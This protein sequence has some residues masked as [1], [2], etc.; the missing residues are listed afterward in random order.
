MENDENILYIGDADVLGG[1]AKY[2]NDYENQWGFSSTGDFMDD[3]DFQNTRYTKSLP[4]SNMTELYATA[5]VSPLSL[6][7]FHYCLENG[8]YTVN[9]HF[10]EI[11]FTNDKTYKSLGRRLFDIYVQVL[12]KMRKLCFVVQITKSGFNKIALLQEKLVWK[13]FNIE[14]EA[15]VAQRPHITSIYNVTV[16]DNILEIRFYWAGRGTTR[17]P[18]SGVYGPLISAFSIVSGGSYNDLACVLSY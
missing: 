5:R 15:H 6:T 9:L 10:A 2:F 8:K 7:Y 14:D 16:T 11:Q 12:I 17:I 18:S 3:D 1:A 4:S 13:D